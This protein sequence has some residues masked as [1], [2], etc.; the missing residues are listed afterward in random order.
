M[1]NGD[2]KV[3]CRKCGKPSPS[4]SFVLDPDYKM[5]VCQQCVKDKKAKEDGLIKEGLIRNTPNTPITQYQPSQS[6]SSSGIKNKSDVEVY[7]LS[8]EEKKRPAGWDKDDEI[9]ERDAAAKQKAV[10]GMQSIGGGKA[11]IKCTSCNYGF[12]YNTVTKYPTTC[13]YCGAPVS[14]NTYRM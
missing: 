3:L 8:R 1:T 9:L 7:D 4:G 2:I 6:S 13:P 12:V 5:V 11:K 14:M 10:A